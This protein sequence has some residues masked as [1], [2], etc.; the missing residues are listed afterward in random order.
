MTIKYLHYEQNKVLLINIGLENRNLPGMATCQILVLTIILQVY[1]I[2]SRRLSSCFGRNR[3]LCFDGIFLTFQHVRQFSFPSSQFN[4]KGIFHS[5]AFCQGHQTFQLS[6]I[7]TQL[8]NKINSSLLLTNRL[9]RRK[10]GMASNPLFI[11]PDFLFTFSKR[12]WLPQ[13]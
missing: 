7:R 13:V 4:T 12:T 5:I 6:N 11:I 1:I 8:K 10:R 9:L 2:T 3:R